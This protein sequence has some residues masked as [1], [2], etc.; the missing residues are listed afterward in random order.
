MSGENSPHVRG[1]AGSEENHTNWPRTRQFRPYFPVIKYIWH[2]FPLSIGFLNQRGLYN[3]RSSSLVTDVA[4]SF[5]PS[6]TQAFN[7]YAATLR[8]RDRNICE[9]KLI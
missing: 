6:K 2:A 8:L 4:K 3:D 7:V 5:T 1:Y 9:L